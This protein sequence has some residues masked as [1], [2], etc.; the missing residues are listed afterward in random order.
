M[1]QLTR[2]DTHHDIACFQVSRIELPVAVDDDFRLGQWVD[3]DNQTKTAIVG[4]PRT[5]VS[6]GDGG[7]VGV[8]IVFEQDENGDF[9]QGAVLSPNDGV[10]GARFGATVAIHDG[11]AL[12]GAPYMYCEGQGGGFNNTWVET[13]FYDSVDYDYPTANEWAE[14]AQLCG[15]V[16]VF[17][18]DAG[19]NWSQTAKLTTSDISPG[20]RLGYGAK[21][22][23]D[24]AI[25]S[26]PGE[27]G[28][29]GA[30]YVFERGPDGVWTEQHKFAHNYA[31]EGQ[32]LGHWGE[33]IDFDHETMVFS[34]VWINSTHVF[35][36]QGTAW[37]ETETIP[38]PEGLDGWFASAASVSG[39]WALFDSS[40]SPKYESAYLY[41]RSCGNW[42]LVA[43]L[44]VPQDLEGDPA[45]LRRAMLSG[46]TAVISIPASHHNGLE[47]HGTAFIYELPPLVNECAVCEEQ[48]AALTTEL[49]S[50]QVAARAA[51]APSEPAQL[52]GDQLLHAEGEANDNFG[53]AT[54]MSGGE[55]ARLSDSEGAIRLG[56]LGFLRPRAT[57]GG[58]RNGAFH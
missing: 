2:F 38:K 18:Q 56:A 49:A 25:L 29:R 46:D 5:F 41:H 27:D 33:I 52:N 30:A 7:L 9:V 37:P 40:F 47:D 21:L 11:T 13:V 53:R 23:G 58:P 3:V 6:P 43:T 4:S 31:T 44:E 57:C 19:G 1:Q 24:T 45:A 14:G 16:Y 34:T 42:T 35:Q 28:N 54:A 17:E 22:S 32:T 51:S 48:E 26:A 12:V 20:D 55:C 15:A 39:D 36:K 10:S 8:A 50:M